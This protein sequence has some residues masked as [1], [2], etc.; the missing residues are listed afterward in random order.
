MSHIKEDKSFKYLIRSRN[1][2]EI[3]PCG[4]AV[5]T[6]VSLRGEGMLDSPR[7]IARAT[8]RIGYGH[9]ISVFSKNEIIEKKKAKHETIRL[10]K[11]MT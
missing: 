1:L 8:S 7:G 6:S 11:R 5:A 10:L 4:V 3:V 2:T 9:V